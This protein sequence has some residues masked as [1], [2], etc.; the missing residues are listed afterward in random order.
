MK[1]LLPLGWLYSGIVA[2]RNK[3]FDWGLLR[4][5]R[6]DVSV[7]SVGNITVGGTGKTPLVEYVVRSLLKQGRRAAVV[8]R[9]YG[10]KSQGV[11][12]VSNGMAILDDT[13]ESGDEPV[14]IARK[15]PGLIVV[16]GESRVE[17]AQRARKLGAEVIVLDDGFQHRYLHRDMNI[18]LIDTSLPGFPQDVLPAGIARETWNGLQRADAVIFSRLENAN[19]LGAWRDRVNAW[20]DGPA[21]G[22]ML[23]PHHICNFHGEVFP[24]ESLN[25]RKI[26]AFSG[27]GNN[28]A[29]MM[30]LKQL[31]FNIVGQM[32]FRD[33]HNYD[34][35]DLQRIISVFRESGAT[36]AL[37]TEKDATRI[38]SLIT[39]D[40]RFV[41]NV[42]LHYVSVTA[43][44]SSHEV[45]DGL[46]LKTI[47]PTA[48][49]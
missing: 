39:S 23:S 26:F 13:R 32:H 14:Q 20:Y 40:S 45:F 30:S 46:L 28:K 25:D 7:I 12:E 3:A 43:H 34:E 17:A 2:L 11:V 38:R 19:E 15:F 33:H 36:V 47:S 24:L 22:L 1:L 21:F 16:V 6:V 37:T 5:T 49:S 8:S 41:Q 27:I 44:M 4:V 31:N 35:N 48:A 9:G 29:F 10:R 42:N 18:V